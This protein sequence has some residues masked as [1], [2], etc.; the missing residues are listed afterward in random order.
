MGVDKERGKDEMIIKAYLKNDDGIIE[1][2]TIENV[3]VFTSEIKSGY[4]V[5]KYTTIKGNQGTIYALYMLVIR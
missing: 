4:I 5:V 2:C 1:E 3:N